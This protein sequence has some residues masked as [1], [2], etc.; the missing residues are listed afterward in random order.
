MSIELRAAIEDDVDAIA[1][2][3]FDGWRDGH[4]GHVD[5]RLIEVRTAS[6]FIDRAGRKVA[7][8]TV[9]VSG[10]VVVGF[11][12][13]FGN[14]VEQLYVDERA[15]GTGLADILLR[16][17]E[18]DIAARGHLVAWLA[19]VAGN[20]RA[21]RFYER[22]GWNDKGPFTYCADNGPHATIEVVAHRYERSTARANLAETTRLC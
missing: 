9:A 1:R 2:I 17:C 11:A 6:S 14:E 16:R 19:V 18:H 12:M 20:L 4:L 13:V 22:A 3:W 5:E 7:A 15:R 21:R 8:T 10:S